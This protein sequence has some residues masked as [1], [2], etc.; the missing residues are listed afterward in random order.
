MI[1]RIITKDNRDRTAIV[2]DAV[3]NHGSSLEVEL[4]FGK[5]L[6]VKSA[7]GLRRPLKCPLT[8]R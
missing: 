5:G 3:T 6:A 8:V 1:E 2:P 7:R 4:K